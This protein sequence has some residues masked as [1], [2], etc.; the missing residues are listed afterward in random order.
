MV[1]SRMNERTSQKPT[2][3]EAKEGSY[4]KIDS[5]DTLYSIRHNLDTANS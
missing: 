5:V 4:I 3:C 1:Y 2:S